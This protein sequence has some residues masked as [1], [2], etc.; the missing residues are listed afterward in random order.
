[1]IHT[2]YA[3]YKPDGTMFYIGKGS[4]S[5]AYSKAG[6]NVVWK[7]TV[8]KHIVRIAGDESTTKG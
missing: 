3:H 5:R 1:M 6:R 7:R 8:E 2:T 4:I